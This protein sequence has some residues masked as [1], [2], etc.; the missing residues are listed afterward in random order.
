MPVR[1]RGSEF[2]RLHKRL[3]VFLF[4]HRGTANTRSDAIARGYEAH[5][6]MDR[7]EQT[8]DRLWKCFVPYPEGSWVC[9]RG[10]GGFQACDSLNTHTYIDGG[11]TCD[12]T[13]L[14]CVREKK[15]PRQ[16]DQQLL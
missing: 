15:T 3:A 4:E 7:I 11:L 14:M 5:M 2:V 13:Y 8:K 12:R 6:G 1:Q 9:E 16:L 10:R